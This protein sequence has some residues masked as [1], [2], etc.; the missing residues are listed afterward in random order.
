[1]AL[2]EYPLLNASIDENF[3]NVIHKVG[4]VCT[5]LPIYYICSNAAVS[6]L[7]RLITFPSLWTLL[8]VLLCR[9][10]STASRGLRFAFLQL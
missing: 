1:M 2:L 9:T 10:S 8:E 3:E 5:H 7:R 6:Y 4:V